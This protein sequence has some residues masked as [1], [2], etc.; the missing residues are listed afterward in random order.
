MVRPAMNEKIAEMKPALLQ[1]ISSHQ[2]AG[3]DHEDPHT[4]L[5]TFYELCS[6]VG[7]S[8]DDEEALFMSWRDVETKFLAR[9]FPP[10]KN[11]EAKAAIVTFVQGV[12]EP[13]C[14]AW[15]RYKALLRKCPNH[16]FDIE[17][18]VQTFCNGLQPQTKMILDASFGGSV[19]FK[20]ADEAITIIESMASTDLRSQHGRGQ[21][22]RRGVL[23]L[24]TQDALL[25]QHK[26]LTQQIES[27]NQ[28]MAKLPQQLQAMHANPCQTQQVMRLHPPQQQHPPLYERTTKLE[29]TLQQFMQL[30]LQNQKNTDASIKNLEV[31]VGQLAKQLADQKSG[32]FSANTQTNSKEHCKVVAT[33]SGKTFGE[34]NPSDKEKKVMKDNSE[35]ED[36][37][38]SVVEEV[39]NK[40]VSG[41]IEKKKKKIE[42]EVGKAPPTKNLPYPHAPSR[43]DKERQFARFLDI[44]KR[45]QINIP[46]SEALEQMPTYAKFMKEL[47]SKKRRFIEEETIELEAG[48]SAIIQKSLPQKY[49]DPGSFTIPVTIGTLPV[50]KALLDL[51]A[52][53][54]LMP[55]SMMRR[56]G[57]LEARPTRM[58][59]QL[60]NRSIKYP[61]GVVEDVLV[62][63][64]NFMFPV[65][66][67]VMDMEEDIE[68][69][70]ILG[71]PFTLLLLIFSKVFFLV[72]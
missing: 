70:L 11:T 14:E 7:I 26:L 62:K 25:A 64:D 33:R 44:F 9:F 28:Q 23:E 2:F 67:V 15:E 18:Q 50:G 57:D 27:L 54:N 36:K 68:V 38:E 6:S 69:P 10:S 71:R 17:M 72:A 63:V 41:E 20:T 66:F 13:L 22:Q 60:A 48:C 65:D 56:I 55:L 51:G 8:G 46:F 42:K 1:L 34:S 24:S 21:A 19:L 59:L 32:S 35:A 49:K 5:Y 4:H 12:D 52:S 29:D 39:E 45:L 43:K 40:R 31:Q 47:L 58:T 16:G 37:D 61:H 30:S 3:L 53:I